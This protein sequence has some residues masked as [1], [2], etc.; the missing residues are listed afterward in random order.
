MSAITCNS[1]TDIH[2]DSIQEEPCYN[3]PPLTSRSVGGNTPRKGKRIGNY[4][5][6]KTIGS[7]TSS[8]VKIG[9]N[10]ITGKKVAIKI[11]KPKRIKERKEIEREITILKLLKHDN[12]I[13]LYDAIYD[14]ER[15]RICLILELV[16]G[17]ELFDYI[18][19]RGRL[20]EREARKFFRQ[21]LCGL[22]YCHSN[23][24]CHRD[25]KLENLLVD[26]DGNIKISDFGYSNIIKPGNLMSTFCG[27][28]VYAPPEIL[29]ERKYVGNEVDIWS[30]G[31]ILFAMVT[32]QL[33]WS[34]TDG[35][36]VEGLD[37]L[38]KGEFK[39]PSSVL[40]SNEVKDLIN[41]MIIANPS[42]RAKLSEIKAH[43]WVNKGY[44]LEPDEEY[45]RKQA[46]KTPPTTSPSVTPDI[47]ISPRPISTSTNSNQQTSIS[48]Q[49][50]R[51]IDSLENQ[52]KNK[53]LYSSS[54]NLPSPQK[55]NSP[56]S[57]FK[58][59]FSTSNLEDKRSIQP[60][61]ITSPNSPVS[62]SPLTSTSTTP[63]LSPITSPSRSGASSPTPTTPTSFKTSL[64]HGLFK[65]KHSSS[66][67]SSSLNGGS[68]SSMAGESESGYII[69]PSPRS[70]TP[71]QLNVATPV[72]P[73]IEAISQKRRFSL[74]DLVKAIRN[75]GFSKNK[76]KL[77]SIKGPFTSLTTTSMPPI[78]VVKQI[79]DILNAQQITYQQN[80]F[81]FE[82]KHVGNS[83]TVIFEIEICR[84]NGMDMYGVK[85]KRLC[86]NVWDYSVIIKKT[87]D[88]L[89]L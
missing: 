3:T 7:G 77:R 75:K 48:P 29:L 84:V 33:P 52:D 20:S 31:I 41:K 83:E 16:S 88:S 13:Q 15:G 81:L 39:Y 66:S 30:L 43:P 5:V 9:T 65:K 14:D 42:D 37:R 11:T 64:F 57:A 10:I 79:E 6:G 12:I 61:S 82:C 28:P 69:Q 76:D 58:P 4:L 45:L 56:H 34:L 8:K 1:Y 40:L 46:E 55:A 62:S 68:S 80:G 35:V 17:G 36:Q 49:F 23:M 54:P 18:V 24:I 85:F 22:I 63:P 87:V 89:Q 53:P 70:L 19:A 73:S 21:I 32:G 72:S 2:L 38:L 27:S 86:G 26:D 59:N 47:P 51:I 44:E 78:E 60:L 67:V 25:L 71:V 74:E 50:T